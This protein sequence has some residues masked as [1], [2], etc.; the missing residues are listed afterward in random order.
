V[1]APKFSGEVHEV[2]A[3]KGANVEDEKGKSFPLKTVLAVPIGSQD[4]DLGIESGPGA[5][6]RIRQREM[7]QD[8][9]RD[10]KARLP[11]TGH[12][13][14][15][16]AQILRGIHGFADTADVYGP[17]K[18]GRIV[19][20]LKLYPKLFSI[21]GTGP[22]MKVFPAAAPTPKPVTQSQVG[23]ASS[24]GDGLPRAPRAPEVH[25]RA[26]YMRF[27]NEQKVEFRANPARENGARWR[28][29]EKYKTANTI[30]Q[31]RRLG[32][33]PQDLKLDLAAGALVIM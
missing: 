13:L 26:A 23:G 20:F 14:A 4:V 33:S 22:T 25:P 15:K 9:A 29:Y 17:A 31:A 28:R 21:Q 19:S 7:L 5:G 2:A 12:T 1:D 11:T 10:L 32:A 16:V 27:P 8:F 24:S 6:R 18:A 3:L 30:G